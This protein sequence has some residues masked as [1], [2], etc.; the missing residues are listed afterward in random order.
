MKDFFCDIFIDSGKIMSVGK[1]ISREAD[2]VI[3]GGG[4]L[5]VI[6][7]LLICTCISAIPARHIRRTF[8]QAA[9]RLWREV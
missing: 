4:R 6:P 8:L 1:N 5:I 9:L 7:G 2:R 3:D